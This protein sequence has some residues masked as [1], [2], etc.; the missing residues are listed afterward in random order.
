MYA[1]SFNTM[2][3]WNLYCCARFTNA[4]T[5]VYRAWLTK[6]HRARKHW[7]FQCGPRCWV[8]NTF[9]LLH[10]TAPQH[11]VFLSEME[12]AAVPPSVWRKDTWHITLQR[13]ELE[14]LQM[15]VRMLYLHW[16]FLAFLF[17]TYQASRDGGWH[18][19]SSAVFPLNMQHQ[20]K[21]RQGPGN[22]LTCRF[23]PLKPARVLINPSI[24]PHMSIHQRLQRRNK[25]QNKFKVGITA[26][27]N[28]L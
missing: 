20:E 9:T 3:L 8:L 26:V 7:S 11:F 23:L 25:C 13:K 27:C 2:S 18:I 6:A 1:L 17:S 24:V 4:E 14:P 12:A 28:Q 16:M 5:G 22:L 19:A 21:G 15:K 10:N